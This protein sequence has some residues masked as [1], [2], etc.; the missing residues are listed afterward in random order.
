MGFTAAITGAHSHYMLTWATEKDPGFTLTVP[1]Q[2]RRPMVQVALDRYHR[3]QASRQPA[4]P[5]PQPERQGGEG[6]A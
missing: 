4:P 2:P 3:D 5:A 6:S 1:G